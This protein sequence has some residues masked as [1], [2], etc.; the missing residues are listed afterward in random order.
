MAEGWAKLTGTDPLSTREEAL[1]VGRYY[2]Y[3][4]GRAEALGYQ[5]TSA[6]HAVASSLAWLIAEGR[7]PRWVRGRLR[8]SPE[9]YAARDLLPRVTS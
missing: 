5:H 9:V 6:R 2:W 3:D 7:V 8:M 1:T 4:S